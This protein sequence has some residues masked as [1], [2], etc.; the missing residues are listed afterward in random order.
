[1][2]I[3]LWVSHSD[4]LASSWTTFQTVR[5]EGDSLRSLGLLRYCLLRVVNTNS[6]KLTLSS[7]AF[8]HFIVNVSVVCSTY[9]PTTVPEAWYLNHTSSISGRAEVA[10]VYCLEGACSAY[11]MFKLA[12]A[13]FPAH[14]EQPLLAT[15]SMRNTF[16]PSMAVYATLNEL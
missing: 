16:L 10:K 1:M 4:S 7:F 2:S 5:E 13:S 12:S 8:A 11:S 14:N 3:L 9:P 6:S 15:N